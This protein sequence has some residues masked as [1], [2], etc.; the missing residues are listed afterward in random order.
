VQRVISLFREPREEDWLAPPHREAAPEEREAE[1]V[2]FRELLEYLRRHPDERAID[3]APVNEQADDQ[4][5]RGVEQRRAP[6]VTWAPLPCGQPARSR[7][8]RP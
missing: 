3:P 8:A 5:A 4:A 1:P 6:L 7:S 2:Y